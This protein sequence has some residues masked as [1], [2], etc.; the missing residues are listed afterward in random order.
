MPGERL[1]ALRLPLMV[2]D[3]TD[4]MGTA[5]TVTVDYRHGTTTGISAAD[6]AATIRDL[7]AYRRRLRPARLTLHFNPETT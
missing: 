3:G 7:I 4:L 5:Y 1:D 6:R 2:N